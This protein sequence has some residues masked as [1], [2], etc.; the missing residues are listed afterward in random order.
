MTKAQRY[1]NLGSIIVP[2][3]AVIAVIV[4]TWNDLVGTPPTS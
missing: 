2:F 1:S 3:A 4:F